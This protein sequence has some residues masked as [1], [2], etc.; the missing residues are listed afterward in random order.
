VFLGNSFILKTLFCHLC[1]FSDIVDTAT[2]LK[3][4]VIVLNIWKNL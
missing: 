3:L 4:C 1:L 2:A